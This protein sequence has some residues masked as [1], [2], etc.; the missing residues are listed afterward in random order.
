LMQ[1]LSEFS[2]A[3]NVCSLFPFALIGILGIYWRLYT[4]TPY[5][6]KDRMRPFKNREL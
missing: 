6:R 3:V 4:Y 5:V 2:T 1:T